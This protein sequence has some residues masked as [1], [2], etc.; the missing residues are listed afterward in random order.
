[1]ILCFIA[2]KIC[3]VQ[4][5]ILVNN[6]LV[7]FPPPQK[8]TNILNCYLA[9]IFLGLRKKPETYVVGRLFEKP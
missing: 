8:K 1:M 2:I 9:H 4:L 5:G 6:C 3:L 7:G